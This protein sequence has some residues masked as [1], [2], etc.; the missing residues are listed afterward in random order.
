MRL[1]DAELTDP[2]PIRVLRVAPPGPIARILVLKLD[3]LGDFII[4][5][6][7][8][9]ALRTAFPAAHI[10]LVCGPWN[11]DRAEQ[12]GLFDAIACYTYFPRNARGWDGTP[13]DPLSAFAEAASGTYDLA[14]DLRV[15]EDTRFLLQHVRA[16]HRAGIGARDR[17]PYLDILLPQEHADREVPPARSWRVADIPVEAFTSVLRPTAGGL[18]GN[19]H[20]TDCVL[21][22][23]AISLPKGNFSASFNCGLIGRGFSLRQ[24]VLS[25][26]VGVGGAS[27]VRTRFSGRE[28]SRI[29]AGPVRLDFSTPADD[30]PCALRIFAQGRPFFGR[31]RFR[32]L[33]VDQFQDAPHARLRRAE[34][35]IGEKLSLLVALVALRAEP[36]AP[37]L[38]P[39]APD[40]PIVLAPY[41]NSSLRDWPE[42]YY[43][44][45]LGMLLDRTSAPIALIGAPDQRDAIAALLAPLAPD[46]RLTNLAGTLP[47]SDLPD[48]LRRARLVVCN[49]S[50][51]A[52]LAAELGA[53]LLALYSASHQVEEWGPRGPATT[54]LVATLPCSPCGHDQLAACTH[55]HACLRGMT[56]DFVM[57]QI[58]ARL[59]PTI[60]KD[61][62]ARQPDLT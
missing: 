8:M 44:A 62:L 22:E 20:P 49:N 16:R 9:R 15:D 7:A 1:P 52:H 30:T 18:I 56:P 28:C 40:A 41:S 29:A 2:V 54:V 4:G 38:P 47:W 43:A 57:T 31:F 42:A 24:V 48:L 36:P 11:R 25:F 3:H 33:A 5:L 58:A 53:P 60:E 26:E 61:K 55:G 45:L 14:L 35:H 34:L 23:A 37:A 46:Q 12:S 21:A 39:P 59:D 51:I 50:G 27:P 6:P 13:V 17:Q 10:T 32:G 19:F